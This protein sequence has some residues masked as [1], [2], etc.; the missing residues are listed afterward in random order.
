MTIYLFRLHHMAYEILVPQVGIK[1]VCP[2]VEAWSLN[3]WTTREFPKVN[4]L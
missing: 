3:H 1:P 4:F 2:A